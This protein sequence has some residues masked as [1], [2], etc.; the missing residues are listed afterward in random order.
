MAAAL[1]EK[2]G[3]LGAADAAGPLLECLGAIVAGGEDAAADAADVGDDDGGQQPQGAV[4][5]PHAGVAEATL[6][7][8]IRALGPETV[9][10]V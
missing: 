6:G 2:L 3:E 4:A 10:Q 1:I 9:L 8:A 5:R 7:T